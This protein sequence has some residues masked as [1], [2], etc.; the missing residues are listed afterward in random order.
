MDAISSEGFLNPEAV[1][2]EF[3]ITPG[4]RVA[5]FGCGAGHI[6]ILAAQK[7]GKEGMLTALDI[8]EDKLDSFRARAKASGLENV[9]TKRGNLEVLGSTGLAD[10][11]QDIVILVNILFQS[12]KKADIL[13]EAKRVLKP[14]GS[15]I[16]V[17]WKQ[18]EGSG[19]K[20]GISV[21]PPNALR[22]NS[23]SLQ[24]LFTA[25]GFTMQRAFNAG[26]FHYGLIFRK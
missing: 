14:G 11:S 12:T 10:S 15:A 22:T 1:V 16:V 25:E 2:G 9:E 24:A 17:E 19:A 26:Q 6:G 18:G 13:K 5:D 3:G 8:M 20:P 23:E 21:G 7:I 4:M